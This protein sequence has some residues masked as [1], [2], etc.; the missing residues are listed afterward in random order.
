MGT[1]TTHGVTGRPSRISE[2][3]GLELMVFASG[4]L[5]SC[6][7]DPT[8][9]AGCAHTLISPFPSCAH[10]PFRSQHL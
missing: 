9:I 8:A 1:S 2:P 6:L 5:M 3:R 4:F 7:P 10:F